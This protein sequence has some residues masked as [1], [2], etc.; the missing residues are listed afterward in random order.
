MSTTMASVRRWRSLFLVLSLSVVAVLFPAGFAEAQVFL[1]ATSSGQDNGTT[2]FTLSHTVGTGS[3]RFLIVGVSLFRDGTLEN[4][5]IS[6]TWQPTAGVLR[7]LS[8]FGN[9]G[10]SITDPILRT[11]LWERI[12][13][14]SGS[15]TITVTLASATNA[16][17]G[18]VSF[19]NV[20]PSNPRRSSN[21]TNGTDASPLITIDSLVGD[22]AVTTATV[23]TPRTLTAGTNTTQQWNATRG[24]G[25]YDIR[26]AGGTEP[27][28]AGTITLDWS[29]DTAAAWSMCGVDIKPYLPLVSHLGRGQAR[30]TKAG[31][32]VTFATSYEADAV[33]YSLLREA[34]DGSIVPVAGAQT[35]GSALQIGRGLPLLGG[36]SYRLADRGPE[37]AGAVRYWIEALD[38]D[39]ERQ[40]LGP[41]PVEAADLAAD[42]DPPE[43]AALAT[44]VVSLTPAGSGVSSRLQLSSRSRL[45]GRE[46]RTTQWLLASGA[47]AKLQVRD[48]GWYR[49]SKRELLAAGFD[50][51]SDPGRLQ[52]FEGGR[53]VAIA[54]DDGGDGQFGLD[55]TVDF[56]GGGADT[57]SSDVRTYWLIRGGTLGRRIPMADALSGPAGQTSYAETVERHDRTTYVP[58]IL[59]PTHESYYGAVVT[60]TPVR[61]S[62]L[63]DHVEPGL[64]GEHTVV[65]ALQ[66]ASTGAH[67]V[68]VSLNGQRIGA[69]PLADR[70]YK[71]AELPIERSWLREG[72]NVVELVAES[73]AT[74]FTLVDYVRLNYA[75]P[76][77][78]RS[79]VLAAPAAP[80]EAVSMTGFPS[81]SVRVFDVTQPEAVFELPAVV[82]G[83]GGSFTV[84][85]TPA[86]V[87]PSSA[88]EGAVGRA[89]AGERTLLA[90]APVAY[91]RLAGIVVNQPSSWNEASRRADF[92][93]FTHRDLAEA[94]NRLAAQRR[95][96]GLEVVVV[97]VEDVFDE[98]AFGAHDPAA[99]RAFLDRA[100]TAWKRPPGFVLLFGDASLD[101]RNYTGANRPDLVPTWMALTETMKT[102]SDDW[103]VD[104]DDNAVPDLAIGRLPART[105]LDA[106]RLVDRLISYKAN[107][108]APWRKKVLVVT[109]QT[110]D[111]VRFREESRDL[112]AAIPAG[113]AVT[114]IAR[115]DHP[116]DASFSAAIVDG[117]RQGAAVV[118]Y[119]GHGS[120][121]IWRNDGVFGLATATSLGNGD[122][123]PAV[124][125]LTCLNGFFA[126]TYDDSLSEALLNSENGG[127][128]AVLA[129]SALTAP[130]GEVALGTRF[131]AQSLGSGKGVSVG[132]ALAA[133]KAGVLDP[134][135][136]KTWI[137]LGDPTLR[138]R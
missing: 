97:D 124:L 107:R 31:T 39:G 36:R 15:G 104:F 82:T 35:S 113:F 9:D 13:P 66:G 93:I 7:P 110:E 28:S 114:E 111:G 62:L 47:A 102:A 80:S 42:A 63:L 69:V 68:G 130:D 58:T 78:A 21:C 67:T 128:I 2:S 119:F 71:V 37:A 23:F 112:I 85:V 106:D 50:P 129:S 19:Y 90:V 95:K 55:D 125:A 8:R 83:Q 123:L 24:S 46:P 49:V 91:R 18:A 25:T 54:V 77:A 108:P 81:S 72:E 10:I 109:D 89:T 52:L 12:G 22:Y 6:V 117:F 1:D 138:L 100:R 44:R 75:R 73:G 131:L 38:L 94:A 137:L 60:G 34:A 43:L 127:A 88:L 53:E 116:N 87:P 70:E 26:G 57:P 3:N 59:D 96:E 134:D 115:D 11:E 86:A 105:A 30:R 132:Q 14:A 76:Y 5:V 61:Q 51:G 136:R 64:T 84:K 41:I 27:G 99:I 45:A 120:T 32:A 101:P 33:Q 74:D 79:G 133:A 65:V 121:R 48:E 40:V 16:V 118:A 126:D 17:A 92:V 103:F 4:E 20:D 29:L 135:V 98:F 56:L 122:R